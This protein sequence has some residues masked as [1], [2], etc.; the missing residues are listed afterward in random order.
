M[1]L[2]RFDPSEPFFARIDMIRF[3]QRLNHFRNAAT[4]SS[5]SRGAVEQMN[6]IGHHHMQYVFALAQSQRLGNIQDSHSASFACA[7]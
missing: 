4:L 3:N 6:V 5:R 7:F 2:Y 1:K